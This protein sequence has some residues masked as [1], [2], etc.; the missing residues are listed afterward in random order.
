MTARLWQMVAHYRYDNYYSEEYARLDRNQ[1]VLC[2]PTRRRCLVLRVITSLL[3]GIPTKIDRELERLYLDDVISGMHW[4]R[5]M[6]RMT[7]SWKDSRMMA[8]LL[9]M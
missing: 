3:F 9:T 6:R 4:Q 1:R 5:F 2:E 7:A 8:I